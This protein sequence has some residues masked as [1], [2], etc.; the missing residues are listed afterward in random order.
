MSESGLTQGQISRV[1]QHF[2]CGYF[3]ETLQD[4]DIKYAAADIIGENVECSKHKVANEHGCQDASCKV[5][6]CYISA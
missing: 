4:Y 3:E 5:Y 1:L 2:S 6:P